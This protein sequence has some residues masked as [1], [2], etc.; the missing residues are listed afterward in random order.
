VGVHLDRAMV[1][2]EQRRHDLAEAELRQ[3]LAAEPDDALAHA[4]L[5]LC[6]VR[7][8]RHAEATEEA[9]TAIG[10][11]PDMP[12]GHH[13]LALAL[14]ER[15][16]L[17]EAAVAVEEAIRLDPEDADHF[18]LLA[19][20]RLG[21]RRWSDALGAADDGLRSDPEHVASTNARAEALTMLGRRDEAG[22]TIDTALTRDPENAV[23]HANMGWTLLHQGD[24][25][26]AAEHFREALRLEPQL[27]WARQGIVEA[28]KARN[29][30]YGLLL[31]YFLWSSRLSRQYQWLL[32]IGGFLGYRFL[33]STL[34]A[35][36]ELAPWATPLQV[37]YLGF[38]L[39]TWTADA[40]FNLV[41]RLDRF[42]RMVLTREEIA[43]SNVV[44][45]AVVLALGSLGAWLVTGNG[46]ILP[47]AL[48]FG[49]LIVPI[50]ATFHCQPGWPRRVMGGITGVLGA[51]GLLGL[52]FAVD[53]SR[54]GAALS[55]LLVTVALVG[56]FV[57]SW[58]GNALM[59]ARP[60][61]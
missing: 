51:A 18:A 50:S 14:A 57:S 53:G 48:V 38:V 52:W 36:P 28:L 55:G 20:I 39:L 21:Q 35:S 6:L 4:L 37:V 16:R 8:G 32:L 3:E 7:S 45:A 15:N 24:P 26:R 61:R 2:L 5:A 11:A 25:T 58:I 41:L 60:K 29:P 56:A 42:G 30:V 19:Q 1:L 44:G 59:M 33:S 46:R 47:F 49:A 54:G 27:E 9:Q 12:L 23:S 34:R 40:L 31:R 17:D 22:A 10:R 43:Q 13:A